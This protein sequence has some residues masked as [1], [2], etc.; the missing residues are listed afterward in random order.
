MKRC[1]YCQIGNLPIESRDE[2]CLWCDEDQEEP[3]DSEDFASCDKCGAQVP[4][5][6]VNLKSE[7]CVCE[8]CK[9]DIKHQNSDRI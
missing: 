1:D 9:H 4:V 3:D 6:I 5:E 8:F 2:L 7:T